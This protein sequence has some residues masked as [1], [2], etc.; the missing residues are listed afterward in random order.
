M[1]APLVEALGPEYDVGRAVGVILRSNWFFSPAAYRQR[2]KS[3]VDYA[4]NI[5][6]GLEG[7]VPTRPLAQ[8]LAEL[9]QA[10]GQPPTVHGWEGGRAWIDPHT[11]LGRDNLAEALLSGKEPYGVKLNPLAVARKYGQGSPAAARKLFLDLFLQGDVPATVQESLEAAA[12]GA[13]S[14]G[15]SPDQQLRRHCHAVVT[16][17]E[18]QLA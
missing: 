7:V 11:L 9:G 14:G 17:P 12:R 2:V 18:F 13:G 3:P 15:D 4:L 1:I 16:L 8:A 10:L 5:V 6:K